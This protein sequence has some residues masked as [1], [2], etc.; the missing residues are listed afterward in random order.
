MAQRPDA[1]LRE[2]TAGS[3]PAALEGEDG[4]QLV[5]VLVVVEHADAGVLRGGCHE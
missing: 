5:E 4:R 2:C 3:D 1:V